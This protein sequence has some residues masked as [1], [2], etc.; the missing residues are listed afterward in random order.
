MQNNGF[1]NYLRLARRNRLRKAFINKVELLIVIAFLVIMSLMISIVVGSSRDYRTT[2]E[3][4]AKVMLTEQSW[5]TGETAAATETRVVVGKCSQIEVD[6]AE[7]TTNGI[8]FTVAIA[9]ADGGSLYSQA[10]I[11]DNGSTIYRA[12]SKGASDSDFEAF[13]AAE[14]VTITITPSGDPG[15]TGATVNVGV[16]LE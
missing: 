8:T 11:A 3:S 7:N 15:A 9:T 5:S 13:L 10:A 2:G 14:S 12:Y 16:Y 1:H 4:V 6:V